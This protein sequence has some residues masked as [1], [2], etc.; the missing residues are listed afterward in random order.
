MDT[1][2]LTRRYTGRCGEFEFQVNLYTSIDL[3]K[4]Y[5]IDRAPRADLTKAI[6]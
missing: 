6:Y 1:W 2:S 5:V 4:Q 3:N